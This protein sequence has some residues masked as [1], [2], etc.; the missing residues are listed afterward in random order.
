MTT[1]PHSNSTHPLRSSW[2][3]TLPLFLLIAATFG[4]MTLTAE[5]KPVPDLPIALLSPDAQKLVLLDFYSDYCGTC[6]MMNPYLQ[7]LQ[8]RAGNRLTIQHVN[9]GNGDGRAYLSSFDLTGTPTYVLYNPS[10][11]AI[12]RMSDRISPVILEQQVLRSVGQLR[13]VSFPASIPLPLTSSASHPGS[14]MIL[15][16]FA[17]KND[18]AAMNPYLEGFALTGPSSGL[19]VVHVDTE[20]PAGKIAMSAAH[21]KKLPAYVL[22][23]ATPASSAN[24]GKNER[25]AASNTAGELFRAE[26]DVNPK[27]LWQAIRLFNDT[28]L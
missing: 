9:I 3:W 20:T 22:L 14:P 21:I 23:D 18:N 16:A 8:K 4:L 12:Y 6:L 1:H 27:Q 28:G 24:A 26:G 5:S 7:D 11:K 2:R 25:V 15:A 13:A 10:R 19:K 17:G